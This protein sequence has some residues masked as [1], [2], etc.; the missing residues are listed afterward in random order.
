MKIQINLKKQSKT[1][2][3]PDQHLI[4]ELCKQLIGA[5]IQYSYRL[6]L[7]NDLSFDDT[8][9]DNNI[10]GNCIEHILYPYIKEKISTFERG[11]KQKAPDFWNR[12]REYCWEIKSFTDAPGFDI[13]NF[14]SF[15]YQ[16]ASPGGLREKLYK[17][18]YLIFKY[19]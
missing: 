13:A 5:K 11:P 17:T 4:E 3:D 7:S 2:H 16:L 6:S 15:I 9:A 8:I 12:S 19:R 18:K 14:M 1:C 10:N